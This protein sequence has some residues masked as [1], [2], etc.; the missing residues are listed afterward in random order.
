[1]KKR[2]DFFYSSQPDPH[3]I[4]TKLI[5][6]EH[7]AIR[8][9]IGKNPFSFFIII[10]LVFIQLFL[11]WVVS[12]QSWWIVFALA[13]FA[14]AF[15]HHGLFLMIHECVHQLIF[16]TRTANRLAGLIANLPQLFP[17]SVSFEKY[18]LRHHSHQGIHRLD[19]D[20]PS[21]WEATIINNY[22]IGKTLWLLFN[23]IFQLAR[24]NRIKDVK[25][26]DGWGIANLVIQLL[27]TLTILYLWGLHAIAFLLLSFFFSIGLHPLGG[28]WV[29][30]H[31]LT[32]GEQE[33]YSYYG[34]LNAVAFNVGF[35]NEH[36][37]FPSVPWNKLPLVR[38]TAPQ[39]YNSLY[40][41]TSWFRLLLRFLFDQEI[42]LFS[43][44]VRKGKASASKG[45]TI[46]NFSR[47]HSFSEK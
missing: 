9:L 28:R 3:S 10:A 27:F 21:R 4:R 36:H 8:R 1:M 42:S 11:A 37:D 5:I 2:T 12:N 7:P 45:T 6:K 13:Y 17:T 25:V 26:L 44:I 47:S 41:H 19:I 39:Y 29:Q 30:E 24:I 31:F 40:Y 38:K 34:P 46:E 33:T 35:H 23:P 43:R 14:G 18:H 20:L 16:K 15:A 32:C 22:F